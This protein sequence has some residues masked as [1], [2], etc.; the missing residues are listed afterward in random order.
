MTG[1]T[2]SSSVALSA[3]ATSPGMS[4]YAAVV[5]SGGYTRSPSAGVGRHSSA[6]RVPARP[7]AV[8]DAPEARVTTG[9]DPDT[10][11]R[12]AP[13]PSWVPLELPTKLT[14]G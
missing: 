12:D 10:A 6:G 5:S 11:S 9:R 2:D 14:P 1:W 8:A 4:T 13:A 3:Q 7:E